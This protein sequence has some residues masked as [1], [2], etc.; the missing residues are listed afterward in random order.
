MYEDASQIANDAVGSIRI[1]YSFCA[2]EKVMQ[3]YEEKC[4]GPV[5]AGMKEAL[6]SGIGYGMANFLLFNV[7]AI[8]F[9]AEA[10]L[11]KAGKANCNGYI[12]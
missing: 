3:L 5:K 1:V 10:Q 4:E 2:E 7:Y 6:I 8:I 11:V 12:R 9:Y